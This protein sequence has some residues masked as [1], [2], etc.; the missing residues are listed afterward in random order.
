MKRQVDPDLPRPRLGQRSSLA[1]VMRSAA[2]ARPLWQY[3]LVT[4]EEG[5][6]LPGDLLQA[7]A[8][9]S[10][11]VTIVVGAGCSLEEPTGLK[12]ADDYSNEAFEQLVLDHMLEP[13]DCANPRDLSELAT[14]VYDKHG[15]QAALVDR[16]PRDKYR[17]AR[18]NAGYLLA[19][20]LIAE[21]SVA[22]VATLNFD[23]ALSNSIT[24]IQP[25]NVSEV[26]GPE[27]YSDFGSK[28]IVYLHRNVNALDPDMWVLRKDAIEE[29]WKDDWQ[30]VVAQRIATAPVVVFAG[31]GSPA[32]ALTETLTRVRRLIPDGTMAFLVDPAETSTF[33][34]AIELDGPDH[35]IKRGWGDF[36]STLADRLVEQFGIEIREACD[37]H[38]QSL[39]LADWHEPVDRLI[40]ALIHLGLL[41]VGSLR[42]VW[43]GSALP[44]N[45]D[46]PTQRATIADLLL[47]VAL[48]LR[49]AEHAVSASTDGAI[50]VTGPGSSP[51]V[52]LPTSGAGVKPWSEVDLLAA[53]SGTAGT[54]G[55]DVIL[56]AGF[57]GQRP[58]EVIPPIDISGQVAEGDI[59][60]GHHVPRI[61]DLDDLRAAPELLIELGL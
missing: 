5:Q 38:A 42:A 44:Y 61:I 41:G 58:P 19:A 33:A 60:T 47:G 57:R 23:L 49:S 15:S 40:G 55:A 48:F 27:S 22:C 46:V 45:P 10:G 7:V 8:Q 26:A 29:E 53:K 54:A 12:L 52:V 34:S 32:L 9:R 59:T 3:S 2:T 6:P 28:A 24:E 37:A 50:S 51:I 20:A 1:L 35:H 31:L 36:M 39:D 14:A 30:A 43:L 4:T 16:L 25:Q 13:G 21:G 17:S 18:A 11:Q 56:T